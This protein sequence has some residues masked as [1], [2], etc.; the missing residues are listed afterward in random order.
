MWNPEA[1]AV[2]MKGLKKCELCGREHVALTK[3]HLVPRRILKKKSGKWIRKHCP[4]L[5]ITGH[6]G[7][8]NAIGRCANICRPC[9]DFIHATFS[10]SQLAKDY[11]TI[12]KIAE[13]PDTK[14]WVEF[15]KKQPPEKEIKVK[16]RV[17]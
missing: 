12:Q 7:K 13:H 8:Y 1:E 6:E 9:H 15:V 5:L 3:H 16:K 10:H 4:F 2:R 17:K 14:K 11:N